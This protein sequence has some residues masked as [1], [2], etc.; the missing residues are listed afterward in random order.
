MSSSEKPESELVKIDDLN[1]EELLKE[2]RRQRY[3]Y[4]RPAPPKSN[5][6]EMGREKLSERLLKCID[7]I[8]IEIKMKGNKHLKIKADRK[9]FLV[10]TTL[11]LQQL[12]GWTIA[13]GGA[14]IGIVNLIV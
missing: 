5:V 6:D 1:V 14:I 3:Q 4:D 7:S 10:D 9:G 8:S 2:A 13:I 11:S 12:I